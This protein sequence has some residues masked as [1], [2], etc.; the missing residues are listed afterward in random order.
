[1]AEKKEQRRGLGRGL[2]A[3][4]SDV[5]LVPAQEADQTTPRS[6]DRLVPIESVVPN[7]DQPRRT[8]TEDHLRELSESIRAK[9]ILQPIIVRP[10][11]G[12]E[13]QFEIVAGERRWRAAQLAQLHEVPV[14]VRDLDDQE[15]IELNRLSFVVLTSSSIYNCYRQK[16]L[17]HTPSCLY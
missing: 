1:M 3:L 7:K 10:A 16:S 14:L 13:G 15:A 2:S 8:F 4:M 17:S 12:S 9:G 11:P 5:D 6:P